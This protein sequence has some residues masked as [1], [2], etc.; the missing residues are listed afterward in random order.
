MTHIKQVILDAVNTIQP[1]DTL[2]QQHKDGVLDW[3]RSDAP[4]FRISKPDNPPKHLVSYFVLY[5]PQSLQL[6]L[7]DHVK[8]QLWL[9]TGGHVDIDED[10]RTTVGREAYEELQ[11]T[12]KFDTVFG[13]DPIFMTVT[14]IKG[15]SIHTDVSLWYVIEGKSTD[16]MAYDKREMNSYRWLSLQDV[17]DTDTSELD[18]HMHRFVRKMQSIIVSSK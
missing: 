3:I 8:A 10:P 9:P 12:A 4:L 15:Q 14:E 16:K 1:F 5:D 6:M 13:H 18:P 17:I 2:E 7:I 11:I